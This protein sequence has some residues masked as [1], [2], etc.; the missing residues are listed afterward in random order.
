MTTISNPYRPARG[1]TAA[2]QTA[3]DSGRAFVRFAS[4]APKLA[5]TFSTLAVMSVMSLMSVMSVMSL[6]WISGAASTA[7]AE[8]RFTLHAPQDFEAIGAT[9]F[10][11]Q[12]HEIGRSSF[13]GDRDTD[14]TRH[15]RVTMSVE[16]GGQNVSQ[17]TFVP[18][19][20]DAAVAGASEGAR[21]GLETS[22][23]RVQEIALRLVEQRSQATSADGKVFPLLVIDHQARRVSCIPANGDASQAEHVEIPEND[24]VVN[25]PMQLLFLPMVRGEVDTLNFQ[26]AMCKPE[27][28]IYQMIAVRNEPV[29][30]DGRRIIQIEYGPDLGKTIAWL[31]SRLL[32]SF[33]FWFDADT[34]EYIGHRMP[35]H[36]EGPEILLVRTGLDPLQIGLRPR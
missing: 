16:G 30:R 8:S 22:V 26:V 21:A 24:R 6:M 11:E 7:S 20:L 36:R 13:E 32:P 2:A 28:V 31:A 33:A 4:I 3:R 15:M 35:L 27:P 25:V 34:G 10:D 5:A 12:G 9:T 14:G 23:D 17:A 19:P 18:V 29:V 1:A